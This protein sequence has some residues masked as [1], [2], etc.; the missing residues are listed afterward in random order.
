MAFPLFDKT[1]KRFLVG[2]FSDRTTD[3]VPVRSRN[4]RRSGCIGQGLFPCLT[5]E[6]RRC[7][8]LQC[9][10]G[11]SLIIV[12]PPVLNL[13]PGVV[14][15]QEPMAVQALLPEA[16]VE[17]FYLGVVGWRAGPAEVQLN[18]ALIR[19]LVHDLGIELAAIVD[20][21]RGRQSPFSANAI[22]CIDHI[23]TFQTLANVDGQTL[24][25]SC[26]PPLRPQGAVH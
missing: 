17:A 3:L 5:G 7:R 6:F 8:P 21:D 15:R 18:A 1:L 10:V 20:L 12:L 22:E 24:W 13:A 2:L 14:H 4:F 23:F 9:R 16:A 25:C 11:A 19:L 26:P